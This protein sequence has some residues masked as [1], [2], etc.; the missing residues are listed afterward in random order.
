[1][2]IVT[3]RIS[4]DEDCHGLTEGSVMRAG[5]WHWIQRVFVIRGDAIAKYETDLGP[6]SDYARVQPLAM[7]SFG[8]NS[9]AQLQAFAEKNRHDTYWAK[10]SE[11]MLAE[12]TLIKDHI[13]QIEQNRELIRNRSHFGPGSH[14]QRNGYP[15]QAAL[16]AER[17]RRRRTSGGTA[18]A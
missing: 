3:D 13:R 5:Q 7:P 17:G 9:V 18:Q 14:F 16:E 10:R 8:E 15:R 1:M 6:A 11:E 12:S 2:H 4:P